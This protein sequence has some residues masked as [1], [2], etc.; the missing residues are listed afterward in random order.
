MKDEAADAHHPHDIFHGGRHVEA[1]LDGAGIDDEVEAIVPGL[2]DGLVQIGNALAMTEIGEIGHRQRAAERREKSIGVVNGRAGRPTAVLCHQVR[3]RTCGNIDAA[4][5]R[6]K[7]LNEG[8][9]DEQVRVT[10]RQYLRTVFQ[11]HKMPENDQF[12][13]IERHGVLRSC[14]MER[15]ILRYS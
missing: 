14:E 8:R 4:K 6:Q 15:P 13:S 10:E 2:V 9:S 1:V 11:A 3:I 12:R 7:A 5:F